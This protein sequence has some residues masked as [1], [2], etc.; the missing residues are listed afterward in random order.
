[1]RALAKGQPVVVRDPEKRGMPPRW[2]N[3]AFIGSSFKTWEGQQ[4][5]YLYRFTAGG[6]RES[7]SYYL[8]ESELKPVVLEKKDFKDYL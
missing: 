2:K 8:K 7:W 1:M 3:T 5:Y 4:G 6:N